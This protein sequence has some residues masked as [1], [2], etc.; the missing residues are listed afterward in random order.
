M[1][2]ERGGRLPENWSLYT[3]VQ[4]E[5]ESRDI[6]EG[7]EAKEDLTGV[8]QAIKDDSLSIANV[9]LPQK[10]SRAYGQATV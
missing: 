4:L 8:T 7:S 3:S 1:F 5:V 10:Q 9:Y 2:F 6:S